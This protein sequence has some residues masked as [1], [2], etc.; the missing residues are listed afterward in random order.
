[1]G[2]YQIL[3]AEPRLASK[4]EVNPRY[5]VNHLPLRRGV[6]AFH[7]VQLEPTLCLP[8]RSRSA[9]VPKAKRSESRGNRKYAWCVLP[10][11]AEVKRGNS[12]PIVNIS[13]RRKKTTLCPPA[14][15]HRR[16]QSRLS[17]VGVRRVAGTFG[18]VSWTWESTT[19]DSRV[20]RPCS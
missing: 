13:S 10:I 16:G 15:S 14:A 9:L 7:L 18:A 5:S 2:E 19:R 20:C 1:M 17:Q 6:I 8:Q 12:D 3:S 11:P 4:A